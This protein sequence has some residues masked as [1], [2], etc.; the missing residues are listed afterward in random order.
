MKDLYLSS[1]YRRPSAECSDSFP[2]TLPIF[3]NLEHL[4]FTSRVTFFVGENGSGKSTLLE[5]L[6]VGMQAIAAGSDQPEHD[7]TLWVAHEFARAYR[8]VRHRHAKRAMF[9]RA[10]DVLGYTLTAA[11]QRKE[12][13]IAY[14]GGFGALEA[15][16]RAEEQAELADIDKPSM[17]EAPERLKR[18]LTRKYSSDPVNRSHG[19]TFLGV[20][21]DRLRPGGLYLLDEPETPL[22]P[23]RVLGLLSLIKE[24][25]GMNCQFIVATHS[26]ILMAIPNAQILLLEDA[27]IEPVAYDDVEHVRTTRAFLANPEKFMR[28]L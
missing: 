16:R 12:A 17:A 10:E 23:N 28:H 1:I 27:K 20:L 22:S 25:A 24:R 19:E 13:G 14:K 15:A 4:D 8:F 21:D 2:W 18:R 5:A 7:A 9:L 3:K 11:R 6:A 26:P